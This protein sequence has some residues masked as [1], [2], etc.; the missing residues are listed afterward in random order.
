MVI[1]NGSKWISVLSQKRKQMNVCFR[2][3][4]LRKGRVYYLECSRLEQA[5]GELILYQLRDLSPEGDV[6]DNDEV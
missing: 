3:L 5:L 4:K 1:I 6:D 2:L